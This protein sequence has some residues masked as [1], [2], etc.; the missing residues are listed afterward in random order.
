MIPPFGMMTVPHWEYWLHHNPFRIHYHDYSTGRHTC[1]ICQ[2]DTSCFKD[3][4]QR[5]IQNKLAEIKEL[6]TKWRDRNK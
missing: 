2:S 1:P 5:E 4:P 3:C 6:M